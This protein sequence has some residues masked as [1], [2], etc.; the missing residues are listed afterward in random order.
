M[1]FKLVLVGLLVLFA[2]EALAAEKKTAADTVAT[3]PAADTAMVAA[4]DLWLNTAWKRVEQLTAKERAFE[5]ERAT[6]VAGVRG[7]EAEDEI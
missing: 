4:S 7:K 6:T 3:A 5:V 2:N 1:R